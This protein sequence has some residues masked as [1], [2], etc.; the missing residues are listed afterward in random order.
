MSNEEIKEN[1]LV[2]E[3]EDGSLVVYDEYDFG[4]LVP[5][6]NGRPREDFIIIKTK[7]GLDQLISQLLRIGGL[8]L[9]I[10]KPK[11]D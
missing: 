4:D 2:R 11:A 10:K 1:F 7:R 8:S 9:K 6:P 3:E 5:D